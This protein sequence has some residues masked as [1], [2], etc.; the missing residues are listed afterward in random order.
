MLQAYCHPSNIFFAKIGSDEMQNKVKLGW[1]TILSC[2]AM[3]SY[4]E[5]KHFKNF[6]SGILIDL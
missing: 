6:K 5:W 2:C 1:T 4:R 3:Y